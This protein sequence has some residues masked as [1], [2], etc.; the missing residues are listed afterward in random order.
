MPIKPN[1]HVNALL[2]IGVIERVVNETKN[3]KSFFIRLK[4][5]IECQPGQFVMIWVP[6]VREMPMSIS[7]SLNKGTLLGVTVKKVGKGTN[8]LFNLK[9]GDKVGLRGPYGKGFS[10][11]FR[12]PLIV[13]GGIGRDIRCAQMMKVGTGTHCR[14]E[15]TV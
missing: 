13:A 10:L 8:A 2:N 14:P 7:Y 12:K 15:I 1:Q 3:V 11:N 9:P 5:P 6:G 4:N